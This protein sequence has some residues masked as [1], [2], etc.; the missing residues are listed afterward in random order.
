[1]E[2]HILIYGEIIPYQDK[3]AEKYGMINLTTVMKQIADQPEAT[4]YVLHIHS[5]GGD[6]DEAFAIHD[7]IMATG[8]TITT[9]IEGLCA[10][11]ATIVALAGSVRKMTENSEFMIH[12][13][14]GGQYGTSE[15]MQKAA[16]MLKAAEEKVL[17]LYMTATG[18]E[19]REAIRL[20]MKEETYLSADQALQLGFI[21]EIAAAMRAVARISKIKK[22]TETKKEDIEKV[23]DEKTTP[24]FQK[25]MQKLGIGIKMITKTAADGTILDFGDAVADESGIVVGVTAT[26][27]GAPANGDYVMPDGKTYKFA[28]GKLT[29][30][31]DQTGPTVE[32][33]QASLAQKDQ[34][35]AAL[36]A[37]QAKLGADFKAEFD[38]FKKSMVSNI[39]ELS[40]KGEFKK[41]G[42][43]GE[44]VRKPFK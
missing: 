38:T 14:F 40:E 15:E 10:S 25:I 32:E 11:S 24:F 4:E 12:L 28:E 39:Q 23:I 1:M 34:E 42:T 5:I 37:A 41:S 21:T 27:E 17:D 18:G 7:A 13:P 6:V 29:E 16:D 44:E 43:D 22:D 8:K 19:D 9:V 31:V 2:G 36:K 26:V 33:L 35:I 3:E 30:I 20:L